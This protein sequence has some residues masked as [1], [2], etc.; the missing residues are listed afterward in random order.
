MANF[1]RVVSRCNIKTYKKRAERAG[2]EPAVP[3]TGTA[4]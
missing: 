2:F 4:V 3:V 1:V